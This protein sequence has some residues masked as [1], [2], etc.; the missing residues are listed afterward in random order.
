MAGFSLRAAAGAVLLTGSMFGSLQANASEDVTID[1]DGKRATIVR[2]DQYN[3]TT[4][5][6]AESLYRQIRTAA[7]RVCGYE[8]NRDV[9]RLKA[10]VR[11]CEQQAVA[12][13]V[14]QVGLP[15]LTALHQT[16]VER[17][18]RS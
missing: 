15:S 18:S 12:R 5:R 10:K 3:L 2:V 14:A 11:S 7:E 13:A 8:G 6:G 1:A 16:Q 4:Q 17:G 9:L